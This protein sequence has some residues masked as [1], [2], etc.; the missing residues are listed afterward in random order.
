MP[1]YHP[2]LDGSAVSRIPG[3]SCRPCCR[4][5]ALFCWRVETRT[6]YRPAAA[7]AWSFRL[8][9]TNLR[10]L[11]GGSGRGQCVRWLITAM[12]DLRLAV[13]HAPARGCFHCCFARPSGVHRRRA[14]RS[15]PNPPSRRRVREQRE[16]H[17]FH[18]EGPAGLTVHD[19][20]VLLANISGPLPYHLPDIVPAAFWQRAWTK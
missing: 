9:S 11:L 13:A 4:A 8:S 1:V 12:A 2:N 16:R 7:A 17:Q 15:S 20:M 18:H 19:V 5:A 14:P 6:A 3:A 10:A